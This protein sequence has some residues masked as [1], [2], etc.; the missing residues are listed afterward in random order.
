MGNKSSVEKIISEIYL[1]ANCID[2]LIYERK[3]LTPEN[4][5][6]F[7]FG[8]DKVDKMQRLKIDDRIFYFEK[9]KKMILEKF[10]ELHPIISNNV[11]MREAMTY[12]SNIMKELYLVREKSSRNKEK[13]KLV[14]MRTEMVNYIFSEPNYVKYLEQVQK[15]LH[16]YQKPDSDSKSE[17]SSFG[18]TRRSKKRSKKRKQS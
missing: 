4:L 12:Y 17:L 5:A 6:G 9:H 10:E 15:A 2:F 16:K 8:L 11:K 18:K 14:L 1:Y 7:L 13:E 3:V